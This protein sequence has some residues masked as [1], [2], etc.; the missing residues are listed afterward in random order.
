[1]RMSVVD[2]CMAG[3]SSASWAKRCACSD[4]ITKD[5]PPPFNP[6][7]TTF[8][9]TPVRYPEARR[10]YSMRREGPPMSL[11]DQPEAQALLND[12]I[13]TPQAVAGCVDRLTGF[14]QRYLPHFNRS[15]QRHNATLV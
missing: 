5:T 15:A 12:A 1:M 10:R 7:S 14:L 2:C 3:Y 4:C 8:G 11:L 6:P 13:L 9:Y